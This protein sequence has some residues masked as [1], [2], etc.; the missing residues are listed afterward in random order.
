MKSRMYIVF[1]A[2]LIICSAWGVYFSQNIVE[3]KETKPLLL[4]D[5]DSNLIENLL[6][7]RPDLFQKILNNISGYEVQIIYTQINR[8]KN[9]IPSFK[10]YRYRVNSNH[11]FY[12]A[13]LVKLPCSALALEKINKLNIQ[14]FDKYTCMQ[15]DSAFTCQ[16]KIKEDSTA[17]NKI[18]SIAQYIKRMML[19]SDNDAYSRIYEFLGQEYINQ[20]LHEMGYP[21]AMIIHRFDSECNTA[22]NACTNPVSF[23]N[24]NGDCIYKQEL[25]YNKNACSNPLGTVKKGKGYINEKGK[26]VL[27]PKDYTYY[28]YLNLQDI[29]DI[30]HSIIFPGSVPDKKRFHLKDD[31]YRFLY[32]YMSMYPRESDFPKYDPKKFEDSYKKYFIYGSYHEKIANDSIRIFNIVGQ[33]YGYL[34]DCAYIINPEKKTEFMLSAVIYTNEDGIINDGK[35]EYTTVGF[36]FLTNL[37]KLFYDYEIK[38]KKQFLPDLLSFQLK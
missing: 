9:N 37:G 12:A 38:R 32:K 31:D 1:F 17:E 29:T 25:Q 27:Q 36:P 6:K 22:A 30:L 16:K 26:L 5:N 8:D 34:S 28:N 19:V 2:A 10:Q 18:P 3:K 4:S 23:Y 21:D 7:T 13:S 15:T 20:R 33:S 35:Y 11:Y 14:G 24:S